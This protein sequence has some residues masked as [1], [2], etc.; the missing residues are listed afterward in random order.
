[1]LL[2]TV[3]PMPSLWAL[4]R[5]VLATDLEAMLAAEAEEAIL[6]TGAEVVGAEET[7]AAL[8]LTK[9]RSRALRMRWFSRGT[10]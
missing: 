10:R 3:A 1:M 5:T 8:R 7:S 2:L 6:Q 4:E 9:L